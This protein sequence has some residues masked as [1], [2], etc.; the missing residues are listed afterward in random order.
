MTNVYATYKNMKFVAKLYMVD[1]K[2]IGNN[3]THNDIDNEVKVIKGTFVAF[4]KYGD[5]TCR[6]AFENPATLTYIDENDNRQTIKFINACK[7]SVMVF[8][9]NDSVT[10]NDVLNDIAPRNYD[11]L[12]NLLSLMHFNQK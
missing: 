1:S 3:A 4:K 10:F 2:Y 12:V 7:D 6:Y 8:E 11:D 9:N 5:D